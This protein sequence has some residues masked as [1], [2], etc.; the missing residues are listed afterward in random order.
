MNS[1]METHGNISSNEHDRWVQEALEYDQ[2]AKAKKLPGKRRLS[3][4]TIWLLWAL[5]IYVA[6]MVVMIAF[7]I[8]SALHGGAS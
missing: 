6:L 1:T 8:W 3:G 5:R 2:L 4:K 7:Q